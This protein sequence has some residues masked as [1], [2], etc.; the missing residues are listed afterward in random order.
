MQRSRFLCH[1]PGSG[2]LLFSATSSVRRGQCRTAGVAHP[3]RRDSRKGRL[4]PLREEKS[5]LPGTGRGSWGCRCVGRAPLRA[6]ATLRWLQGSATLHPLPGTPTSCCQLA[7]GG[8]SSLGPL[9]E[10][11]LAPKE[12]AQPDRLPVLAGTEDLMGRHWVGPLSIRTQMEPQTLRLLESI[13]RGMG[14]RSQCSKGGMDD[15]PPH[16]TFPRLHC[17]RSGSAT[18]HQLSFDHE[19][20]WA[21]LPHLDKPCSFREP[22]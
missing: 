7:M 3:R 4:W 12:P 14:D 10:M 15:S 22:F 21:C 11:S 13:V 8:G 20:C 18:S 6:P 19:V 1:T 2:G 5:A 17:P 16:P 9:K